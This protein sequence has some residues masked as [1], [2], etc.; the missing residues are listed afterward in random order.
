MLV[1]DVVLTFYSDGNDGAPAAGTDAAGTGN[2]DLCR[3]VQFLHPLKQGRSNTFGARRNAGGTVA[4]KQATAK[5]IP[6]FIFFFGHCFEF[7]MSHR[8]TSSSNR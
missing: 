2:V 1:D 3:K 8:S 5:S 6:V 7:G 4:D